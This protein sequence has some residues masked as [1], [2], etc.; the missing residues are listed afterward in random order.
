MN[1]SE[2]VHADKEWTKEETDYL[3]FVVKDYDTRWYVIH[4]RYNFPDGRPGRWRY[5]LLAFI[6][7]LFLKPY[8]D[9]KDRYYS[10]CRKLI[11][12]RP[13]AGDEMSKALMIQSFQ[14]D[15][16]LTAL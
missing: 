3:F 7:R 12:N 4:D 2:T 16:G 14:F 6:N 8:Q 10:V 15:K 1:C 11:R 5:V 13:W 9:L